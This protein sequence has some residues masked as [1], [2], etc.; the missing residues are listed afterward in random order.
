MRSIE[1]QQLI[2]NFNDNQD[3]AEA[4]FDLNEVG[5]KTIML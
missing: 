2:E 1:I 5:Q 4:K 3:S